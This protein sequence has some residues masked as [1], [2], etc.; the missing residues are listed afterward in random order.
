MTYLLDLQTTTTE[1]QPGARTFSTFSLV[2]LSTA[3][4]AIC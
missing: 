2:C 3:S 4:I 1:T